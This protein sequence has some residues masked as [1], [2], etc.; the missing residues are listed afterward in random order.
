MAVVPNFN[1]LPKEEPA[2]NSS[3]ILGIPSWIYVS[4]LWWKAYPEN[5]LGGRG[6]RVDEQVLHDKST[7]IPVSLNF[8]IS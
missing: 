3:R 1:Y 8:T 4:P 6:G 2:Q 5:P 7:N